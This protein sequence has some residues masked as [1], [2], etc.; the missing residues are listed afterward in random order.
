M[1]KKYKLVVCDHIHQKGLDLLF[2]QNDIDV[3]N[4]ASLSKDELLKKIGDADV[5]LTRSPTD[6]DDKFLEAGKNIKSIIRAGVGVDN[7]DIEAC[8]RKGIVVMNVPTANTIAAVELTMAH[9]INAVRNFPG[10]NHQLKEQRIWK[11]E[12]WYGTELKDKK[13]GLDRKSV[14]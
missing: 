7:V 10:I 8:S 3:L 6:V 11:R 5:A 2:E 14:V 4:Y 12:D 9:I 13:L 1:S